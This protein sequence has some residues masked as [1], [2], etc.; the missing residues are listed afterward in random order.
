MHVIVILIL[1]T[2]FCKILAQTSTFWTHTD[3]VTSDTITLWDWGHVSKSS[4]MHTKSFWEWSIQVLF[5]YNKWYSHFTSNWL[6]SLKKN[7]TFLL[8]ILWSIR[9]GDPVTLSQKLNSLCRR[10]VSNGD[11]DFHEGTVERR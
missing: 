7:F 1:W 2:Q 4:S 5:Y 8:Y 11:E 9:F 10:V 6:E 3:R